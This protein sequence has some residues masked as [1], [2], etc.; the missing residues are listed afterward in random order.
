M[1]FSWNDVDPINDDPSQVLYHGSENRGSISLNLLGAEQELPPEPADLQVFDITVTDVRIPFTVRITLK[2]N[3]YILH[4]NY[5]AT[6]QLALEIHGVVTLAD[7][8]P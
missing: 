3:T 7:E 5:D 1:I 2:A 4:K 8:L 6:R